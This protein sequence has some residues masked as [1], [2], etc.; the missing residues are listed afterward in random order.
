MPLEVC[1]AR[2]QG[3]IGRT[4]LRDLGFVD[5]N[6]LRDLGLLLL[7]MLLLL[8]YHTLS[9]VTAMNALI[10]LVVS[11]VECSFLSFNG[12]FTNVQGCGFVSI[13]LM[14]SSRT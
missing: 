3:I 2:N 1:L 14:F 4:W 8:L 12:K 9:I 5:V 11:S 10:I 6:I 7:S 13:T